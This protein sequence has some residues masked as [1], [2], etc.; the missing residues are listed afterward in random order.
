MNPYI[1]EASITGLFR[2]AIIILIVY[3]IYSIF[4]RII[5]PSVMKKYVNN[6]QQQFTHENQRTRD[7]QNRRK[8]GEISITYVNK[9]K[10]PST[11]PDD[12]E[13]VDYEEIK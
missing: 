10:N 2:L 6:I 9:D 7:E 5:L 3:A 13:Y 4:I 8:E 11:N 1:L 12:A